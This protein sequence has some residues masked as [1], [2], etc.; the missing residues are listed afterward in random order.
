MP[1][2]TRSL[3]VSL[4]LVLGCDGEDPLDAGASD[5]AVTDAGVD[6][7]S[8]DSSTGTVARWE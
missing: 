8:A 6:A 4:V 3:F 7:G 1:T 5:A 2:L